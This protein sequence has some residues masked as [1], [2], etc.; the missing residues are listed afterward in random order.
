VLH[1]LRQRFGPGRVLPLAAAS[2]EGVEAW[3]DVVLAQTSALALSLDIDY[4]TYAAAE[5]ALGWLNAAGVVETQTPFSAQNWLAYLLKM[6]DAGL[7]AAGAE[8]AHVKAGVSAGGKM[9]KASITQNG[10]PLTWDLRGGPQEAGF[11]EGVR[12]LE[13]M[14]NARVETSPEVLEGVVRAVVAELSP[15]PQFTYTFTHFTCISPAAPQPVE[16]ILV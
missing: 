7:R 2:G 16:R 13:F 3:L 10:G 6:L 11:P 8:I 14:L 4:A 15:D 12:R 1:R 5:A 9:Y